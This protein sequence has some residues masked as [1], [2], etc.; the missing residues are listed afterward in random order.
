V[1]VHTSKNWRSVRVVVRL[2]KGMAGR[3][4]PHPGLDQMIRRR[5]LPSLKQKEFVETR[6]IILI[7][8][9]SAPAGSLSPLQRFPQIFR[10]EIAVA[11][12][13]PISLSP[14]HQMAI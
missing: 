2:D 11:E 4:A 7:R 9:P 5:S 14:A 1:K 6:W 13:A 8:A 10:R 3:G 12:V